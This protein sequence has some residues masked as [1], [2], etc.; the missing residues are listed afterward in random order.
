MI[1]PPR[2][3][4]PPPG[5]GEIPVIETND[6]LITGKQFRKVRNVLAVLTPVALALF[7]LVKSYADVEANTEHRVKSAAR[8][9][10]MEKRL[11]DVN[12]VSCA[13]CFFNHQ[14]SAV[15]ACG[16]SC[17]RYS[18]FRPKYKKAIRA[19]RKMT[20]PPPAQEE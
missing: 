3:V 10:S 1:H 15:V 13:N 17:A 5:T 18:V 14:E 6:V 2:N 11:D 16:T 7:F 12:Q 19:G 8:F 9:T 4:T 20:L